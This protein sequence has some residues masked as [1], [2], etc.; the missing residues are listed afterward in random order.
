MAGGYE[1][2]PVSETVKD[3][4]TK[5]A[6]SNMSGFTADPASWIGKSVV[7]VAQFCDNGGLSLL[8]RVADDM[9]T[10]VG[11]LSDSATLRCRPPLRGRLLGTLF[12]ESSTRTACSFQAA[13]LRLGGTFL[14][15]DAKSSSIKKGETLED[16]VMCL[17]SYCDAIALRHPLKGAAR[18]AAGVARGPILNAGDGVGEH[19][20]QALLDLYTILVELPGEASLSILQGKVVAMIGD[21][22]YGRTVH[23]LARLLAKFGCVLHYVSPPSLGMPQYIQQEVSSGGVST[24]VQT[25]H[26]EL[27]EVVGEAD[28]L[29]VTRI[30]QE[31]FASQEEFEGVKGCYR[32]TPEVM[33]KAKPTA[34]LMHPLPRVGEIAEE[35]DLDPR[36]AYFRQMEYGM[37]VRMALLLLLFGK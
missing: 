29:Y 19:P 10:Q 23:S 26:E 17:L 16:T 24:V 25:E 12:Y 6:D 2:A 37:F 28:V 13:M 32:I 35:C 30:Q 7:S 9:K 34:V 18:A 5:L 4:R 33:R 22:K 3:A 14:A 15:V 11:D 36:A 1:G 27:D 8:Y 31:R 21:L 20:T